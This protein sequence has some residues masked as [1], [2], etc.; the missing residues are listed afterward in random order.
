MTQIINTLSERIK[1]LRTSLGLTQTQL[2]EK[3]GITQRQI[4]KYEADESSPREIVLNKLSI[5]LGVSKDYL[6]H[7]INENQEKGQLPILSRAEL[8]HY[9]QLYLSP[10]S[11]AEIILPN[12]PNAF[13]FRY[14]G[15]SLEPY[16]EEGE[17]LIIDPNRIFVKYKTGKYSLYLVRFNE[18]I[19]VCHIDIGENN[20]IAIWTPNRIYPPI[21]L[22]KELINFEILGYV[23][24]SIQ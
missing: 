2:A 10:S 4:A 20:N 18:A 11:Y 1:A 15:D 8:L 19:K 16:Y 17:L 3:V 7:G 13:G 6:L 9:R 21:V 22:D 14:H 12:N 5:A 23:I 24:G